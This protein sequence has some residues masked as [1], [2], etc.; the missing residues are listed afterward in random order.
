M[1]KLEQAL[2]LAKPGG[3][4]RIFVDEGPPLAHLLYEAATRGIGPAYVQ[5]LLAAFPVTEPEPEPV[6]SA[7]SQHSANAELIEPLS[8]RELE[9]LH[10]IADGLTNSEIATRLFLTVNTVKAHN[11]NIYGKLGVNTRTKAVATARGLGLLPP[12]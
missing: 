10:L 5:R 6:P 12:G 7:E 11:H 3:Y 4:V 9:V 8:E 2:T 1:A